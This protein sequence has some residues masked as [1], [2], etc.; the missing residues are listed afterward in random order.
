MEDI[1]D[2]IELLGT[3]DNYRVLVRLAPQASLVE[4]PPPDS[5]RGVYLDIE[6]TGLD[7]ETDEII[8]LA[9]VPFFFSTSGALYG[10]QDPLNMLQEP[11]S[12]EIPL[13]ITEIT[14]IS[15]KDVRGQ[16]IDWARV[17]DFIADAVIVI[18]HNAAFDRPFLEM[19]EPLFSTKAW[20]CS[21]KDIDWQSEGFESAK[22]EYLALK[23]GFFYEGHRATTDCYAG[24]KLLSMELPKSSTGALLQLLTKARR[25][26]CRIWAE[27]SPFDFKDHL[28]RRGYYWNDGNDGRPKSWY[29]DV[30]EGNLEAELAWL[31]CEIYQSNDL[32]PL[33]TCFNAFDRYSNR[34]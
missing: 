5:K 1:T 7:Q 2:A 16:A 22:L 9:V 24:L 15:I 26:T 28:K 31:R 34:V 14:G 33:V 27:N 20:A 4:T 11:S 10:T 19:A 17:R 29:R 18:A 32:E 30:D 12:G 13:E 25:Q 8:E 6:T 21:L 3:N 23:S